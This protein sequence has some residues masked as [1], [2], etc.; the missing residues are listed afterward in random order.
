MELEAGGAGR[1]VVN[2]REFFPT[3]RDQPVCVK[4]LDVTAARVS[5]S[6]RP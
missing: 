5:F 6:C 3:T 1:V 4:T 2:E